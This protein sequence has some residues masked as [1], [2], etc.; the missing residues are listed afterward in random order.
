MQT[1]IVTPVLKNATPFSRT[2]QKIIKK[3][4]PPPSSNFVVVLSLFLFI[5]RPSTNNG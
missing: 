5:Y 2:P 1:Q 3:N 4:P